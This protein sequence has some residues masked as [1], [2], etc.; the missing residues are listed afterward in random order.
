MAQRKKS[1]RR[2]TTKK[3]TTTKAASKTVRK[4]RSA[5]KK[6]RTKLASVRRAAK[7]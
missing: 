3:R 4:L 1:S 6:L 7:A 5:N 2:K